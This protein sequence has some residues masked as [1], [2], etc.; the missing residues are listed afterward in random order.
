MKKITRDDGKLI[1]SCSY[2]LN[3]RY[4][5]P[6]LVAMTSLVINAGNN[7]FYNIYALVSPDFT[8]KNKKIL[9]S[10]EQNNTNHCK[11][12]IIN[13]GNKFKGLDTN[14]KIPTA[15]YYRLELHNILQDVDRIVYMDGDT[16][17][18]QDLSE[19]ITLD[20]EENYILGFLDSIPKALRK[21]KIK[22]A[23]VLC[24]GVLLLDLNALRIN[25]ISEKYN[26][27]LEENLGK[28][29][30]HDQTTINVVCQGKIETL[31]PKYGIW[32]FKNVK[33]FKYHN[34]AH[35]PWLRYNKKEYLLSY[36][37]PAILHYVV[38]KPY[39]KDDNKFYFDKW[40]E[41]AKKTG[42][43]NEIYNFSNIL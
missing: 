13:M 33:Y 37:Y 38:R 7:T 34:N 10:V 35:L 3:N 11:I 43:Y 24:S 22:N 32:N 14:N 15:A 29:Y 6:T 9:M 18:F 12:I 42:Y 2:A 20:M 4:L 27:F 28:I 41:Y 40:W 31:P 21:F 5:Y 17:V 16:V 23:V 36:Y 8:Q 1:L 39:L 26:E 30:Q 19:L 25:N